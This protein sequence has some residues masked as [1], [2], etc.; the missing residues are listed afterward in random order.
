M[1]A[2]VPEA[3]VDFLRRTGLSYRAGDYVFVHAGIRPGV[4]LEAQNDHDMMWIRD[5]FLA[6]RDDHGVVVVH[7]HTPAEG[8]ENLP[9]RI[10]IDTGAYATGRLSA[11]VLE[12][13]S[14]RFLA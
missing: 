12:G 2:R 8:V 13:E 7:G 11:V 9:N 10:G 3:H 4:P 1:R 5:D 6:S 14:R